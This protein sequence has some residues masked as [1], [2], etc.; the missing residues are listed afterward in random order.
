MIDR[1]SR[2]IFTLLGAIL[3][4]SPLAAQEQPEWQSQYAIGLNKLQPHTYVWPY[5]TVTDVE[6]GDY[7][8]SPYYLSLNGKWKFHWVK[9]PDKRPKEF[10]K[11]SFYTGGWADILVPGNWERQGYGTAIYV[12]ESYEFDDKMFKFKK[13]PPLVPYE[14]NE[15]GSYRRTFKVPASWKDRRVVL[16]CEGVISFYYVWVNGKFIGYNQG[17]KTPAEWDITDKLEDGE[18]MI[19]LEVYR[20][21]AGSYLECQDM[22][23]LSGIE[24]DVYLYSTPHRY[25]ADY[26]V[27]SSLEKTNYKD[28]LFGL[29]VTIEGASQNASSIAYTLKDAEGRTV[30][31]EE[32]PVKSRGLSNFISFPGKRLPAVQAWSAEHPNLYTLF[33][34]LKDATGKVT[35]VTGCRVG[36]RTSEIKDGRFCIN[37][38]PILVKGVNRHE[39]SQLGRT[40]SK[41]LMEQDIRLMK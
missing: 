25:I 10:Y 3:A 18:N 11:P 28:G 33:L 5:A 15:V 7:E 14:D 27:T 41:E 32:I 6:Q 34:E 39:H 38:V 24:R 20:W 4:F 31:A 22:W 9:N 35:E 29:D 23:R 30:S 2:Q 19:A 26:K 17:S 1:M 37:G 21:S 12:N 8:Q 16:C 36:F 13:N 40:V